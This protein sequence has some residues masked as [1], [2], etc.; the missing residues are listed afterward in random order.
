M[1]V[2]KFGGT[3]V[4]N[5]ANIK[6]VNYIVQSKANGK[7]IVVV[8]AFGGITDS[9]LE[10]GQ[11]AASGETCYK[12]ALQKITERHLLTVKELLPINNQ[13]SVLSFVMQ[14]FNEV[15]DICNGIFLLQD[16]TDRTKD[17]ILSYG[18]L[19]SS[20]IISAYFSAAGLHSRW[21]DSRKLIRTNSAFTHAAV[22]FDTTDGAIQSF[23]A[24][25]AESFFVL[26][27]F[28]ASDEKGN[29]TT[30]GR[31]GSDYTAAIAGAAL[32][33]AVVEIWTDVPGMMTADPRI[34]QNAK[35]ITQI[36]YHEAMELSHFGAKVIYPPTLQPLMKKIFLFG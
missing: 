16:F 8:S 36:S 30:L 10:C 2:L 25:A 9:L 23:F 5:A 34:V 29:T 7:V 21:V 33:A 28:I 15:E 3:S 35:G 17:R 32:D 24:A 31:G 14:Q 1:Q 19:I 12:A 6:L 18:E 22:D 4:A 20:Q 13:S 11:M 27:G 26:P